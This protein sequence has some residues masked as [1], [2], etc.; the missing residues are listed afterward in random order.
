MIKYLK[1][2]WKKLFGQVSA[3]LPENIGEEVVKP[4]PKPKPLHCKG[5]NR[6]KKSCPSCQEVIK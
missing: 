5:H 3:T 1:K 6:F 2:L 4:I